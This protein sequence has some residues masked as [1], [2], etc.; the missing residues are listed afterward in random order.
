MTKYPVRWYSESKKRHID[1]ED[2]HTAHLLNAYAKVRNDKYE[3]ET[4]LA[5]KAE[6]HDRGV[7]PDAPR[8]E[9]A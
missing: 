1:I 2:M 3:A 9:S 8:Q 7:D 4:A 5:I 6:L